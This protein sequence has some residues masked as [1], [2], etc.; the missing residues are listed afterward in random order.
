[1]NVI[2]LLKK[3]HVTTRDALEELEKRESIDP[4]ELRLVADELVAHM[5]IEEQVFYPRVRELSSDLVMESFEEHAVARFELARTLIAKGDEQKARLKVLKEL[6]L[7]HLREEETQLL[8]KVERAIPRSELERMGA[9]LEPMFEKAVE[10]GFE[11]LVVS[12]GQG[13]EIRV[14][15]ATRRAARTTRARRPQ[16]RGRSARRAH[17]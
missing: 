2:D 12:D 13:P 14:A 15:G 3:Q 17:A 6:V 16:Q 7:Q 11:K 1:M 10:L 8:P 5:M 9:R 4:M